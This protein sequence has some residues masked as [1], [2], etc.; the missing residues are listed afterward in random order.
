[1]SGLIYCGIRSNGSAGSGKWI[2]CPGCFCHRISIIVVI[3]MKSPGIQ[4]RPMSLDDLPTMHRWVNAE[5]V[6]EWWD[7]LPSLDSVAAKYTSRILGKEPTRSFVVE[8]SRRPI[9][10]IQ[11]YLIADY[12][13]YA[14]HV[15]A[16]D[17]AAGVDLLIGEPEYI[18]RGFGPELLCEFLRAIVFAD[19]SVAECIIGPD[20]RNLRAIRSYEK[21]GFRFWKT[22]P[23]ERAPEHLMRLSRQ[24]FEAKSQSQK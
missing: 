20:V 13:D 9:G 2:R 19:D 17:H 18:G 3:H 21:V 23:G 15:D 22:I 16:S 10:Y 14:R 5:H 1:M 8:S 4:F 24:E 6:R 7:P 11:T 12:P